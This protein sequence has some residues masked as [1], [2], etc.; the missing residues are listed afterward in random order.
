[1]TCERTNKRSASDDVVDK[2]NIGNSDYF[3]DKR[4]RV[5]MNPPSSKK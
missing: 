4:S 5:N 1:M 2:L 3:H